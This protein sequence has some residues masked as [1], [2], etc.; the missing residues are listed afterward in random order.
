MHHHLTNTFRHLYFTTVPRQHQS[1]CTPSAAT[2]STDIASLPGRPAQPYH[3]LIAGAVGGYL[4]WGRWSTLSHQ[5]LMY[6]SI[7]VLAALW[8]LLPVHDAENWRRT[9][10]LAA[11]V[12][13][14][15]VLYV[16]ETHPDVLQGSL[17]K[18]MDEI[19]DSGL[20]GTGGGT[21][22]R[23]SDGV[24]RGKSGIPR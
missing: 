13:W 18:S 24:G 3:A 9:H 15:A 8:K 16:W 2:T 21:T 6:V 14:A 5:V 4:I 17:R 10:R 12:A 19:Y 20:F 11:T 7:R 23:A 22:A 1:Q